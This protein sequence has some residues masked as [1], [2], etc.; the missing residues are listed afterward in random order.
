MWASASSPRLAF[1]FC[2]GAISLRA[3]RTRR[4][5]V[6][7]ISRGYARQLFGDADPIGQWVGYEPAPNDHKFLIVGEVADAR[8][9]GAEREAPPVVYMSIN[10]NP[11]PVNSIRV[12][13]VGD[14][15]QL[16]ESVRQALYEV[17]PALPVS[18]IVPLATELNG[19]LGTE[20][21]LARLAG[22][23]A[24]LTL[25]LVAI[26]FY[27]VMSSRTARRK[28]EFGIRLALGATRRNIQMLIVGQTARILLAGILPGAIL[29]IFA[30]RAASHFLYG[31]VSANSFAIIAASLVLAFAGSVA[32]L[33]PARRAAFA[34]PLETLRSE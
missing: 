16:S 1:Q 8:V 12:R 27:G 25:L 18:E 33:I 13:A 34:D 23:Y 2:A 19:D 9:N 17:D 28:S 3:I 14:P 21:L 4:S 15:R 29:S 10:Q 30:V 20:K 5:T 11:A 22:I 6:A 32:T 24:S 7:I 31:S 26:G